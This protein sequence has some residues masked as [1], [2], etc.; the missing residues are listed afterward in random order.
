[1]SDKVEIIAR[2]VHEAVRAYQIVLS[3]S[4]SA[5]WDQARDWERSPTMAG[6]RCRIDNPNA[7]A[8]RQHDQWMTERVG[9]GWKLGS[10]KDA[11]LKIHPC[12]IPHAMLS[13]TERRKDQLFAVVVRALIDPIA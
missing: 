6:V 1:M 3:E 9:A 2:L 11:T 5:A 7:P 8:S 12:L 4:P 10:V 13:E